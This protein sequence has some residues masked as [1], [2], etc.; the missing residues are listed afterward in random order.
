MA[1]DYRRSV[2]V[3]YRDHEEPCR[4]VPHK[5]ESDFFT[6]IDYYII[7]PLVLVAHLCMVNITY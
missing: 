4:H 3:Q 5:K 1:A 7:A 6:S 2:T